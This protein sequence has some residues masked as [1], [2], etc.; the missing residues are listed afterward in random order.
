MW[1]WLTAL[2]LGNGQTAHVWIT[3][4][5][6]ELTPPGALGDFVRDSEH[7]AML[8]HGSMFPDG[9]YA[10][11]HAYGEMAHWEPLQSAYL[12][13]IKAEYDPPYEGEAGHHVAFLFGMASHGMGDQVYDSLYM[14]RSKRHDAELGWS[15][16]GE[17]DEATDVLLA[18]QV[19][20][21]V[22]PETWI[23]G[24]AL[25]GVFESHAGLSVTT[26]DLQRAQSLLRVAVGFVGAASENEEAVDERREAFPW[27]AEFLTDP[28]VAGSPANEAEVIPRYWAELWAR[29]HDEPRPNELLWVW[30]DAPGTG[31]STSADE[32]ESWASVALPHGALKADISAER[33]S[34]VDDAGEPVPLDPWLFYRNDSHIVHLRP[35][36]DLAPE[37]DFTVTVLGGLP[38][39][40]G[41]SIP[42]D[43]SFPASTRE[44]VVEPIDTG[45]PGPGD[46]SN[47][48]ESASC[49]CGVAGG[50]PYAP[51]LLV[52]IGL[53]RVRRQRS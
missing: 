36:G 12:E 24:D 49:G 9:G 44:R 26:E 10:I 53:L 15:N 45:E 25:P 4:Q 33:F 42:Q 38:L 8:I 13:W 21:Q 5:A 41:D 29:L 31:L 52:L 46:T 43:V 3:R 19:G 34:W 28:E 48:G 18:S 37:T 39:G 1:I 14:E 11:G 7:E 35:V 27:G 23:P 40:P 30:P 51:W 32:P 20:A 47:A 16:G 50:R 2:A 22:V 6:I 17:F